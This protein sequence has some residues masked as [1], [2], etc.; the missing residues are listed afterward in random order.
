MTPVSNPR[1]PIQPQSRSLRAT[2]LLA[3]A[4]SALLVLAA[5]TPAALAQTPTM[6]VLR[7]MPDKAK[8]GETFKPLPAPTQADI[9]E[10]KIGGKVA[11]VTSV[12]P[13]L[14]GP[15]T[16]QLMVV[17]D[18]MQMIG[19]NGQFE[20][21]KK[22][23]DQMPSN[24]E[25]GV[26]YMLQSNV[27]VTQPFTTDRKLAGAA[28][29]QKTREEAANPKND[30]GNPYQCLRQLAAH[31]PNGDPTKLRAV[32]LFTDGIIRSNGQPQGVDQ[33][34]PD[35]DGASQSFQRAGI[36]PYPFYYLDYPPV[37]PN[38]NEGG[39]LDGQT[40]FSQLVAFTGGEALYSGQFSPG[41]F[42]PLLDK[43]YS[44]L[45]GE[46]VVTVNAPGAPG[47]YQRL[48]VKSNKEDIK[49]LGPDNVMVGNLIPKK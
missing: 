31:W 46:V 37:D 19:G 13:V 18:S 2:R 47:K 39:Q 34:N 43:L 26:G 17:L 16:L 11:T 42:F 40:N 32:L 7:A 36:V 27:K 5:V 28:L 22:F 15:T 30:N 35:V 41:S 48:D 23:F 49:I 21:I 12:T 14:K 33:L 24:V 38:R 45:Q 20:D 44:V 8:K 9:G 1:L 4:A 6:L 3:A 25:I 29:I 10:I